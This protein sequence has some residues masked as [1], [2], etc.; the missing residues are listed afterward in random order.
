MKARHSIAFAT[1]GF[2]LSA[3]C[4]THSAPISP[5]SSPETPPAVGETA[6][7]PVAAEQVE[8]PPAAA[9]ELVFALEEQGLSKPES[10]L[11]VEDQDIYLISNVNGESLGKDGNGFISKVSPAG[12]ILELRF[13]DGEK[14]GVNL[15]APKGM[16]LSNGTLY[17]ADIT[18]I[19]MFDPKSGAYKGSIGVPGATFLND[20][21][22]DAEG[23]IYVSDTGWKAGKAGAEYAKSGSDTVYRVDPKKGV[24]VAM[25]KDEEWG[26]PNG[27][28]FAS[29]G[30]WAVSDEGELYQ[31]TSEGKLQ[32]ATNLAKGGLDGLVALDDGSFLVS[33]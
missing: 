17:V 30:L 32:N 16:A 29:G 6:P 26:N 27:L 5:E 8:E 10:I 22:K 4:A 1:W 18:W 23:V 20:V 2:A 7:S 11:Y 28:T 24:A 15:D 33:S 12:E 13:I 3:G 25:A 14:A 9:A 31:V 21:T 19:R